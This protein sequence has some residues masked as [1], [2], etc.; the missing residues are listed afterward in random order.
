MDAGAMQQ[1]SPPEAMMPLS[2][3]MPMP[4]SLPPVPSS[5]AGRLG[6]ALGAIAIA[7]AVVAIAVNFVIPGPAGAIGPSG[8]QGTAG[9]GAIINASSTSAG[10]PALS[11]TCSSMPSIQLNF[12]VARAGTVVATAN[13]IITLYHTAGY[14]ASA[15]LTL[16]IS[17]TTCPL[18]ESY[19]LVVSAEPTG[20]YYTEV[21][22]ANDIAL[23]G[24]GTYSI[25][26]VGYDYSSGTDSTSW[27]WASAVGVFYPS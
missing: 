5:G 12:T 14:R 20:T 27:G 17:P 24:A 13:L 16:S 25:Y 9:P 22:L 2:Q 10:G 6:T 3:P 8:P 18:P 7:L 19:A 15:A 4:T 21:G 11:T 23:P 1:P 26:L